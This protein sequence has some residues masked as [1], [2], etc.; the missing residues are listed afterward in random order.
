MSIINFNIKI[1]NKLLL[2]TWNLK[3]EYGN[4]ASDTYENITQIKILY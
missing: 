3:F 1:L 2:I 4:M